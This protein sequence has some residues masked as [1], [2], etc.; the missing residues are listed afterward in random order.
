MATEG[1]GGPRTV[2]PGYWAS[3]WTAKP[4]RVMT[5]LVMSNRA[6]NNSSDRMF[7][8]AGESQLRNVKAMTK[9]GYLHFATLHES[10]V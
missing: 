1:T 9:L 8:F 7:L 3:M 4:P 2:R 6:P 10:W 5:G